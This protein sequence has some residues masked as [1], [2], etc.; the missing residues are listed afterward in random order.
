[1]F[2]DTTFDKNFKALARNH[3]MRTQDDRCINF[4]I[5][6]IKKSDLDDLAD[7]YYSRYGEIKRNPYFGLSHRSKRPSRKEVKS[8][9]AASIDKV[10]GGSGIDYVAETAGK[11]IGFCEIMPRS[12][13]DELKHV[14]ILVVSVGEKYRSM[15][16]G[17]TLIERALKD[18]AKKFGIV[19]LQVYDGNNAINLYK[20]FGFKIHGRLPG[21]VRRG[22]KAIDLI[23]MWKKAR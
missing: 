19:E 16:V 10:N 20:R 7:L 13:A 22:A 1:L 8:W 3:V 9:Y 4:N 12:K 2:I 17:T 5:R 21:G 6:Q 14:G 11:T 15:G 23:L 18:A